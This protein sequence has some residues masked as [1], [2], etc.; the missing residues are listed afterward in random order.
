MSQSQQI[1]RIA[2]PTKI[3]LIRLKRRVKVARRLHRVLKDRLIILI[4]ELISLIKRSL[5]LRT[6]VHE[7][8]V[9]CEE[10]L[11]DA[12]SVSTPQVI[13]VYA[14]TRYSRVSTVVGSRV[15]AGVRVPLIEVEREEGVVDSAAY[16]L[17]LHDVGRCFDEVIED[18]SRLAEMEISIVK[19]GVEVS[20]IK[21]RAN[22]LEN[23]L[24]PRMENTIRFLEMKFEERER[25]DKMRL[26]KV[27]ELLTKKSQG[28]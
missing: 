4:Q 14:G 19:L 10:L 8:L 7:E 17:T 27:K 2:R 9:R 12:L 21:R 28:G 26:K 22:A 3:E 11:L 1:L 16:P 13:E 23:I 15:V 6:K 5:E 20:R 18:V 25:E 24:I